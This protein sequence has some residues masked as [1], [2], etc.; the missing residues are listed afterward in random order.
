M[1][2][3]CVGIKITVDSYYHRDQFDD[4]LAGGK[5]EYGDDRYYWSAENSNWGFGWDIQPIPE[6][7]WAGIGEDR[8]SEIISLIGNCL[9]KHRTEY[10]F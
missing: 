9:N 1:G 10:V 3:T 2:E 8:F 4:W 6:E 5:V 7:E